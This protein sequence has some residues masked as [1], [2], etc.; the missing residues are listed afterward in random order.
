M[1]T[2]S[3]I[4][5]I[6]VGL[7][8]R[9]ADA[10]G[11]AYWVAEIDGGVLTIEQLRAN[12]V[13]EQGEWATGLGLL[14]RE[15]LVTS[16]Y[17]SM[18]NREPDA[19]GLVYWSTGAGSTVNADQLVLALSNGAST[20]DRTTLDNKTEAATYYTENV[21]TYVASE[22]VAAV[23]DV[24][25]QAS[26][27]IASKGASAVLAG[28]LQ[29][30]LTSSADVQT[31]S[32]NADV[33]S[34]GLLTATAGDTLVGGDGTDTLTIE[35][36]SALASTFSSSGIENVILTMYG[37]NSVDMTNFSGVTQ[38]ETQDSTGAITLNNVS[39]SG[40]ALAFDGASTN[41]ITANYSAGALS[42][43]SD[44]AQIVLNGASAVAVD[45]DPGFESALVTV[46]AT[47]DIDTLT[48]PGI[49]NFVLQGSAN[50]DFANTTL[51]G[52][53]SLTATSFS[54]NMTTGAVGSD[55]FAASD[56]VGGADGTSVLLG[57]GADKIGFT[58][59]EDTA[60]D[61][62]TVKLGAGNDTIE[63]NAAGSGNTVVFGEA[64]D[65]VVSSITTALAATDVMI[66]G[67]GT[68]TFK[69]TVND[70]LVLQEFEILN[71]D[72][73]GTDHTVTIT[74]SGQA[75]TVTGEVGADQAL[76]VTGLYAGSTVNIVDGT[77]GSTG[78]LSLLNVGFTTTEA[79]TTI[80]IDT[81][82]SAGA[83]ADDLTVTKVTD[84]TLDFAKA[85]DFETTGTDSGVHIDDTETLT[86]TGLKAIDL[87]NGIETASSL[88]S[89]TAST[90][91]GNMDLGA[92][93][94][95]EL[96][97]LTATVASD[98][99]LTVDAHTGAAD[100]NSVSLS[101]G[102]LALI[103]FGAGTA[104]TSLDTFTATAEEANIVFTTGNAAYAGIDATALGTVTLSA[105]SGSIQVNDSSGSGNLVTAADS[106]G[107]T[108]NL[109]AKTNIGGATLGTDDAVVQNTG[110]DIT[111]TL[112][113]T[114]DAHV[115][116]TV[117]TSGVVNLTAA[118]TGGM[119]SVITNVS[120]S[121]GT[122]T[123]TLG[124]ASSGNTNAVALGGSIKT[125]YVTGGTG[126][127]SITLV[128]ALDMHNGTI[129]LGSGTD[130]LDLTHAEDSTS[131]TTEGVALNLSN[132]TITFDSGTSYASTLTSGQLAE[133]D[134]AG[135]TDSDIKTTDL[136]M[137]VSGVE[138][139]IGTLNGDYIAGANTGNTIDGAAGA[140][141]I[142]GSAAADTIEGGADV[143]TLTGGSG[144]DSFVYDGATDF[145]AV[146][147][148]GDRITDFTA[149][150]D[151]ISF[152]IFGAGVSQA[153]GFY[154]GLAGGDILILDTDAVSAAETLT[155]SVFLSVV[156]SQATNLT[157]ILNSAGFGTAGNV[158]FSGALSAAIANFQAYLTGLTFNSATLF[159]GGEEFMAFG[160]LYDGTDYYLAMAFL[161]DI[162]SGVLGD[163]QV[164]VH[165]IDMGSANFTAAD[166]EFLA[167]SS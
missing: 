81:T 58:G 54:G 70:T 56:I 130:T 155:T 135:D 108:V 110:G 17:D 27:V 36:T 145:S 22:A 140:D 94:A 111:A 67:E 120:A 42:G 12:I 114:A 96:T 6:Y 48:T 1:S 165:V 127:E 122:S 55:G 43:G 167:A 133:Y 25:S 65:D 68:D 38:F 142:I 74:S 138:T 64:G 156:D 163:S 75:M 90:A 100:L 49:T 60:T 34:A 28:G 147:T 153:S 101:G 148:E 71:L 83:A 105:A 143:D 87:G 26:T 63:V 3:Q 88:T 59:A 92:I 152:D 146:E 39:E 118:N 98:H 57:S 78:D 164:D 9:A 50:V 132:S 2:T 161:D 4:Q 61:T 93:V 134:D 53:A 20:T 126:T 129:A 79:S 24:S 112:A 157:S 86:I 113:G 73:G 158:Y 10:E 76:T 46:N 23:A 19:A 95:A 52:I 80:D 69:S 159:T 40:M 32:A 166:I 89:I 160:K 8:G 151:H 62:N 115:D 116:Y 91:D 66:G 139:V 51:D 117:V 15:D 125:L 7:L 97:S 109:T 14:S 131:A 31:G 41:S 5:E 137:T 102:T 106:T 124:N 44:V 119:E 47:S 21:S 11:L 136:N 149:G 128:D 33:F 72:S 121:T 29:I 37:A 144:A 85:V 99:T 77:S 84:L 30:S 150:T 107:I 103:E 104:S 141:T 16:L 154:A 123:I 35:T 13:N 18:F 82:M 162:G 45:V